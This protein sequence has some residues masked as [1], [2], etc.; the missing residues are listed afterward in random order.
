VRQSQQKVSAFM[1]KKLSFALFITLAFSAR[2]AAQEVEVDRYQITARV[3]AAASA[4][5]ARATLT[6]SNLGQSPKSRL[7]FRL[8]TMARPRRSR[9]PMIAAPR[10]SIKSFS[11][12]TRPSPPAQPRASS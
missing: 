8:T 2:A 12:S 10:R 6:I 3:D 11:R 9:L 4:V 5:D 1:L 7:Y